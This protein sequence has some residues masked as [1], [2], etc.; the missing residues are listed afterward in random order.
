M[1]NL[2][3]AG[4]A[5]IEGFGLAF[6]PCILPVLPLIL[7]SSVVGNRWRPLQIVLG[8]I[9]SF[10]LFALV[11]RQILAA[12]GV[13]LDQI[14]Y[15][16]FI[17]LLFFGLILF[18]P[19]F[20]RKF[21]SLTSSIAERAQNFSNKKLQFRS[22]GGLLIGGLIGIVWTPCAG[23]ILAVALLQ[24]IQSQTSADAVATIIAFSIGVGIP[25]LLIA[26][27]GQYITKHVTGLSRYTSSIRRTMGALIILVALLG[28]SGF[29]LGEWLAKSTGVKEYSNIDQPLINGLVVPYSAPEITGITQ[30]IN[31]KPLDAASLKGKVIL[32]DFWTYSCINCI[33]T[34]PQIKKWYAKYKDKGFVVIGVHTPEFAFEAQPDNVMN[35]VKKFEI[36]YPVAMDNNFSTWNS[37]NNH[38]WPAHYL[39]DSTGKVVYTHFGEGSYDITENNIRYLLKLS[40]MVGSKPERQVVSYGQTGETYLGTARSSN[41]VAPDSNDIPLHHWSLKGQWIATE[42][43]LESA[44]PQAK[45]TLHYRAKKVFLVM[46]SADKQPKTIEVINGQDKKTITVTSSQLYEIVSNTSFQEG[47]VIITGTQPGLRLFAFTFEG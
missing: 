11:S 47:T 33:R 19:S 44:T 22:G 4:L 35:A 10:S 29:N 31:S 32:V 3:Q 39:I 9:F 1:I 41:M 21:A 25:M 43:Y 20:E 14:Q 2:T 23:P 46:E 24:V 42:Q 36:N 6:S 34:L 17:M 28:F 26:Y 40:K 15:A 16:A 18:I 30:W 13:Q 12:T 27:G 8:F 38:Y 45:L 5:L 7:A 37:F